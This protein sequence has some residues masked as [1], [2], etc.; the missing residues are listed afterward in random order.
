MKP[1][2]ILETDEMTKY[3]LVTRFLPWSIM[4]WIVYILIHYNVC[5]GYSPGWRQLWAY[6]TREI[7]GRG[8]SPRQLSQG[9]YM[10]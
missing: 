10:P 2:L 1:L 4:V 3:W 9:C 8:R 6:N 5:V 7:I